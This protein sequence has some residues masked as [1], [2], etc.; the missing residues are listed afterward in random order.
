MKKMGRPK[1]SAG[2]QA[3]KIAA[4][5]AEEEAVKTA[6]ESASADE[7]ENRTLLT[8]EKK[9]EENEAADEKMYT[10][11]EVAE[12]AKKAAE[13]AVAAALQ[14]VK[15]QVVQVMADTEKVVMRWCAPVA[16]DNVAVFGPNGM[17]GQVTGKNGTVM[18]PKSEWSRFFDGTMRD[19]LKNRWLVVLGGM[20]DEEREIYGCRYRPGELIDEKAFSCVL[21]MG[22]ELL[23]I[24][25]NLCTEHQEM[26]AKVFY[27]AMER[28]ELG[29]KDRN[30]LKKLNAMSRERYVDCDKSDVR[31]KGMFAPVIRAINAA[32]DGDDEE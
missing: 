30:L 26:V 15:P 31:R 4:Q 19:F 25:G 21:T 28:N 20:S 29:E 27:D 24:F 16:D 7:S 18:V 8:E 12:I 9:K 10:A 11:E 13:E 14:N 3:A 1:N 22:D 6:S 23:D 17:Y 5:A 2:E 32:G